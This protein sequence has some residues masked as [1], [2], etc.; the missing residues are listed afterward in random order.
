MD[1]K[2]LGEKNK[3]KNKKKNSLVLAFLTH[4]LPLSF[5]HLDCSRPNHRP[6]KG[7]QNPSMLNSHT[8]NAR[9]GLY[10][11]TPKYRH[12]PTIYDKTTNN[13]LKEMA[14]NKYSDLK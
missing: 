5:I 7:E 14:T 4:I 12:Q 11:Y 1:S 3:L 13:Q 6:F 9:K 2:S 8:A 10:F